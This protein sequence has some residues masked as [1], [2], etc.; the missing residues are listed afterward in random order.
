[1][2]NTPLG[3]K[4]NT[5]QRS[6]YHTKNKIKADHLPR[7][8]FLQTPTQ[9]SLPLL[10]MRLLH[11]TSQSQRPPRQNSTVPR[12]RRNSSNSNNRRRPIQDVVLHDEHDVERNRDLREEELCRIA[13]Q[14]RPVAYLPL[15]ALYTHILVKELVTLHAGVKHKLPEGEEAAGA[16][17]EDV[18]D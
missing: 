2:K 1:M 8:P 13:R 11:T 18:L 16:V 17:E 9:Q 5:P 12:N 7:N 4:K 3:E 14:T 6:G 15:A 10:S